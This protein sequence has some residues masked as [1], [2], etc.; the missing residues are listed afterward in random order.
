MLKKVQDFMDESKF[1][2]HLLCGV[3]VTHKILAVWKER[4]LNQLKVVAAAG[5]DGEALHNL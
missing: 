5:T 4:V 1:E 2:P 3:K